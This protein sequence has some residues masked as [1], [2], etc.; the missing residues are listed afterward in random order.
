MCH[1]ITD[2]TESSVETRVWN[3]LDSLCLSLSITQNGIFSRE[4]ISHRGAFWGIEWLNGIPPTAPGTGVRVLD[5]KNFDASLLKKAEW[6]FDKFER[7]ISNNEKLYSF[8]I[9]YTISCRFF[10]SEMIRE[11]AINFFSIAEMVAT[12]ILPVKIAEK[13]VYQLKDLHKAA[14]M[15]RI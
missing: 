4:Y 6:V 15:L 10:N 8:L 11:A 5:V 13:S 1:L 7:G 12:L 3:I 14:K 2:V 9:V